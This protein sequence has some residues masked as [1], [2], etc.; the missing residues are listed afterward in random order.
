MC[1][2]IIYLGYYFWRHDLPNITAFQ[3]AQLVNFKS[4]CAMPKLCK[5]ARPNITSR[6]LERWGDGM[7]VRAQDF[8]VFLMVSE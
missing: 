2:C 6:Y 1:V 4:R 5:Y 7:E 8:A 3:V